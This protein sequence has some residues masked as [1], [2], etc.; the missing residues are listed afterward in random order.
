[1]TALNGV[2]LNDVEEET[3][4][5]LI[6]YKFKAISVS[7]DGATN[8]TYQIYRRGGDLK[9]VIKNIEK[10]NFYKKIYNSEYPLLYWK[11]IVFGH[12]ENEI[13][14]AREIAKSLNMEFRIKFN[15]TPSYS[16]VRNKEYVRKENE[17]GVASREEFKEKTKKEYKLP[18]YQ[19]W[20]SPQ[21]NWDGKVLGCCKNK[22]SDF[23]NAF[24]KGLKDIL[25]SEKYLYAKKLL[26]GLVKKKRE[27]IPCFRCSVYKK[28]KNPF[29]I[30]EKIISFI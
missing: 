13:N 14:S 1:L 10:I 28:L 11:F 12:N 8:E 4:E 27:D 22:Y 23:G 5:Y 25:R 9:K 17:F 29:A 16:P 26:I 6:K 21:V 15:H 30:F 24:E 2:N 20:I 19:L 3:L 7:I 18:C